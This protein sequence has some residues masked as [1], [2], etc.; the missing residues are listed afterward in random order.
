MVGPLVSRAQ[1]EIAFALTLSL[2]RLDEVAIPA[3]VL[4][5]L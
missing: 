3:R 5:R 4:Q 1:H 2:L